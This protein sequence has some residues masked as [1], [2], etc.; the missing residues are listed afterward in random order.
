MC[1]VVLL[2]AAAASGRLCCSCLSALYSAAYKLL[3]LYITA[4]EDGSVKTDHD[5]A[6]AAALCCWLAGAGL[7]IAKQQQR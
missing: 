6:A 2:L 3:Q 5:H 1:G 7:S 4:A